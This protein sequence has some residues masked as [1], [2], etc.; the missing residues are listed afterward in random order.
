VSGIAA[1]ID[2]ESRVDVGDFERMLHSVPHRS[3][4]GTDR[5]MGAAA[6]IACFG[7]EELATSGSESDTRR[8]DV[9]IVAADARIDNRDQLL[10]GEVTDSSDADV[11]L[12]AYRRWGVNAASHLIGDFAFVIWDDGKQLAYAARDPMGTR[13]LYVRIEPGRRALFGSEA[14]QL[15]AV[16]NVPRRMNE[17]MV[18]RYLA[19][20]LDPVEWSAY[21]GIDIVAPGSSITVDAR[22]DRSWRHWDFDANAEIVYRSED[23]YIEHFR[24]L[25]IDSVRD[26]LR[27]HRKVGFLLSGGLDSGTAAGVSG[28]LNATEPDEAL[29]LHAYTWDFEDLTQCD[30]RHISRHLIEHFQLVERPIAVGNLG[31]LA[32]YPQHVPDADTPFLGS[33]QPGI[34]RSLQVAAEDG[35]TLV[36]SGDRGDLVNGALIMNYPRLVRERRW[37]ELAVEMRRQRSATDDSLGTI[38]LRDLL[39]PA[40]RRLRSGRHASVTEPEAPYAPWLRAEF[41]DRAGF[42]RPSFSDVGGTAITDRF[43]EER[44]RLILEPVHMRGVMWTERTHARFGLGFA[45]PWSDRRIAEFVVAIP[46]QII[47]RPGR[48]DKQLARAAMRGTLPEAFLTNAR[49]TLPTPLYKRGLFERGADTV[50]A[51]LTDARMDAMGIIDSRRALE[52]YEAARAGRPEAF[53]IWWTLTVEMWLRAHW[54][55]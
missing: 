41:M 16:S 7:T 34:S 54:E 5:W 13:P 50:R 18:A 40:L 30:E 29:D 47:N 55:E 25:V 36:M 38:L 37:R 31:P 42:D 24:R 33:F 45:D 8:S 46:P 20:R 52:Q 17:A 28:W 2:F 49:K 3:A 48:N 53:P 10:D 6:A 15:L 26:R 23:E 14:K 21:E 35:C 22:R 44:R 43:R 11:I 1:I 32:E 19:A 9:T 51:L 39:R 27:D 12:A 4:S